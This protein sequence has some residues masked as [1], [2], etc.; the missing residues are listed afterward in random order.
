M[1]RQIWKKKKYLESYLREIWKA[2]PE[3]N[4]VKFI[5]IISVFL[6]CVF[7]L[8]F[9]EMESNGMKMAFGGSMALKFGGVGGVA[10]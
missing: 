3:F 9:S 6:V 5:E 7:K 4:S 1:S 8:L 10:V 2:A